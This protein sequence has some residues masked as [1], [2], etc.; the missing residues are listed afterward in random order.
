MIAPLKNA[1]YT[2]QTVVGAKIETLY[3]CYNELP[4]LASFFEHEGGGLIALFGGR[5]TVCGS[6]PKDELLSFA[7]FVGAAEIEGLE[8]ELPEPDGFSRTLHPIM[9]CDEERRFTECEEAADLMEGYD[10]LAAADSEF[11]KS[12][13]RWEWLSDMTRRRNCKRGAVYAKNGAAVIVTAKNSRELVIGAVASRSETRNRGAASALVMSVCQKAQKD[14]IMPV[15][16]AFDENVAKFYSRLGFKKADS[17][18]L[19]TRKQGL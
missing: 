13:D 3:A 1:P 9:S 7:D 2:S 8:S 10:V 17:L 16:V 11:S 19:L 6:I 12:C 5:L 4:A 15:T 14:G 18:A